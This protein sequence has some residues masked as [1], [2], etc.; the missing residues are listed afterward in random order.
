M[1]LHIYTLF[2]ENSAVCVRQRR[3]D[4]EDAPSPW[5]SSAASVNLPAWHALCAVPHFR[6]ME[7]G[8]K[9]RANTRRMEVSVREEVRGMREIGSGWR[10]KL[11]G[12][13]LILNGQPL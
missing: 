12:W 4:H 3:E 11:G 10:R 5:E 1:R 8:Q 6:H 9:P 2:S 7:K 13:P